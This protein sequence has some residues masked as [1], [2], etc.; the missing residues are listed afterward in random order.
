MKKI[1]QV[2]VCFAIITSFNKLAAQKIE[3]EDYSTM[4]GVQTEA[5]TDVDGGQQIGFINSGDWLEYT[6]NTNAGNYNID[7]RVASATDGG[8]IRVLQDGVIMGHAI[9]ENT[10]DW[11]SWTTVSIPVKFSTSGSKTIRLELTGASG[12]LFNF[13]WFELIN[14]NLSTSSLSFDNNGKPTSLIINGKEILNGGSTF[15]NFLLLKFNGIELETTSDFT[16]SVS[17]NELTVSAN[18]EN[19]VLK[20]RIDTY[21]RHV[22]M[23]LIDV[24]GLDSKRNMSIQ[25]RFKTTDAIG[26]LAVTDMAE[27]SFSEGGSNYRAYWKYLSQ[28]DIEGYKGGL[29][30]WDGSLTGRALDE[31]L[32]EIWS[33]ESNMPK[34]AEQA[35]WTESDILNWVDNY[36]AKFNNMTQMLLTPTSNTDLYS[37]VDNYVIPNNVKQ[38]YL[39]NETW[40][41][42]Y[43]LNYT[44]RVHVNTNIFPNG[45]DD[46]KAFADYLHDNDVLIHLHS[47]SFGIGKNDP[48][49]I[50]G[51]VDNR[52]ASWGKGK[53]EHAINSNDNVI[54]FRPDSGVVVPYPG[55]T[56][57]EHDKMEYGNFRMG[58]ELL[59]C[60]TVNRTDKEVWILSD[61]RR[62]DGGT[63]AFAFEAGEE[64]TGLY[65]GYGRNYI[66]GMDLGEENS[67][68]DELT[69]EYATFVNEMGLDHLHFDGP[70][71]NEI[72]PY[73][74]EALISKVYSYTNRPTTASR[75]GGSIQ[76][77]FELYFSQIK[78]DQ[79]YNYFPI[80][81]TIRL[82]EEG[83]NA[84]AN[85]FFDSHFHTTES[86]L[87][88]SRRV[89]LTGSYHESGVSTQAI[90]SHG[91][92]AD[93]FQLYNYL[94]ELAP[95]FDDADIDYLSTM[96][97]K[98]GNHYKGE[99]V[100]VLSKNIN[101]EYIYTPYLVL[102]ESDGSTAPWSIYQELGA[103]PRKQT[104]ATD[105]TL[106]LTNPEP[107]SD[108][109][110]I[111]HI[112]DA[113]NSLV[114]PKVSLENG[115]YIEFTG[116]IGPGEYLQYEAGATTAT[117]FDNNWKAIST[118][119]LSKSNF[120]AVNGD[121]TA[122]LTGTGNSV[123]V[124]TQYYVKGT[125]YV[126]ATNSKL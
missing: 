17:G 94:Q 23:H 124:E 20:Y 105:E 31:T 70:R 91:L 33:T 80:D 93:M 19:L 110:L 60:E 59:Q 63:D 36:A 50:L 1:I 18:N 102:G 3:A 12:Y 21:P 34:P 75:V 92:S 4:N 114:N 62:G 69:L 95:V 77:N 30:F 11:N 27:S 54:Y 61:C 28:P 52:L 53:L 45:E 99:Y 122:H 118:I 78:D 109:S 39:H 115:G 5:S 35:S 85:S 15:N 6:V 40:R 46:L 58:E 79:S 7:F 10:S 88:G 68:S 71:I 47:L 101:D 100:N 26:H 96:L 64:M 83:K 66:P 76:A 117:R 13:N 48:D 120:I 87:L 67:L 82:D 65:L 51:G 73:A 72:T 9:V 84:L 41:G 25:F 14:K 8:T 22:S 111:F 55:I 98:D 119:P 49:Y 121:F 89:N 116:T 90:N 74:S 86:L 2:L 81:V 123:A 97:E 43:W 125:P 112:S 103:V 16:T 108:L 44:S 57:H 37:M 38:V 113:N 104:T 24:I 42:E 32:A 56:L 107:Q 126:L 29:V 106:T